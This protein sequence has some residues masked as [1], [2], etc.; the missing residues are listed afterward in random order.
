MQLF[1][2]PEEMK[3]L[4]SKMRPCAKVPLMAKPNAGL[5]RLEGG[6]TFF[7][8]AP[9]EF[10]RHARALVDAGAAIVGGC[11]G[12]TP[13]HIRAL[14]EQVKAV[15]PPSRTP[16]RVSA[17]SSHAASV[18]LERQGEL[19]VIGERINPTGKKALQEEL[20]EG[21]SHWCG[22]TPVIRRRRAPGCWTS[23]WAC[24]A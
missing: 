23:T 5:P 10:A 24:P 16:S 15:K 8:M 17:L 14:K 6:K 20:K 18:I 2:R 21:C 3:G 4:I 7:D 9:V 22:S 13:A 12:T 11:C 19:V 1:H